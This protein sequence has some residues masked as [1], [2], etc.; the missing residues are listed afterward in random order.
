MKKSSCALALAMVL[1][2]VCSAKADDTF[3]YAVQISAAV[4]TN[5]PQI[6]L[7]WEA[8]PFG[9]KSYAIYRKA[10]TDTSW[11]NSLITLDGSATNWT[12]TNV[13]VG[14][15][16]EYQIYKVATLG[17]TGFGYIFAGIE[18]PFTETRGTLILV[19]ATNSAP[20]LSNELSRLETDL[21]GDGWSVIRQDVSSNDTPESVREDITNY[22]W[23]DTND[24]D[25]VF[26]FG[27]VPIL[28]SGYLDYDGHYTRA[29][30]SDTFYG[31]MNDDWRTPANPTNGPSYLPSNVALMVGRVDMFNM[32]GVG[33]AIP[34]PSEEDLLRNYLDKDHN[35][36]NHLIDV[37][38][39]ALMGDRRGSDDGALA[40]AASGYRIF[41][42]CVG[43]G[44][45]IQANI[46]DDAPVDQSW[47]YMLSTGSWLWAFGDG[48]GEMNSISYLGTNMPYQTVL[49]T[50]IVN[51]NAQGVFVLLFGSF[52]GNWDGQDN[53]QRSVLATPTTGLACVMS[54]E[55]HWFLHHMALGETI[56]YGT[57][58]TM[59]NSKLYQN[60]SNIFTRA[61]YIALMGDPTL[62]M[63]PLGPPAN[64]TATT[65]TGGVGLNWDSSP[66]SVL[67]Y[68]IYRGASPSG[69]FTRLTGTWVS[70]NSYVDATATANTYTYMVRAITLQT[71]PSG[72]Y[73][74]LSE[75]AFATVTYNPLPAFINVSI[76]LSTSGSPTLAWNSLTG[77]NYHV[78]SAT[79]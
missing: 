27:H 45:T 64:V 73:Y 51:D 47:I 71:N 14:S 9:A 49:S 70:G 17:Y 52:L 62:R 32:P 37:D 18:A 28:Q 33:A 75:G 77:A 25:A 59:N 15:N 8:D 53:I 58:L 44:N 1:A 42:P 72:S 30:P 10:K 39:R 78:L 68:H 21:V 20:D 76:G 5:P 34:F 43:P 4:Q 31:E 12:D 35:W 26:L 13:I 2:A 36:R 54:G 3:V 19:V 56:G 46:Q 23:A 6:T 29:M 50:D 24:V 16:Y 41:E 38:P 61:V 55:P 22:Y 63:E 67:G 40:M 66:D 79:N 65:T 74:N 11:G 48:G 69:P 57:R 60:A 7:D